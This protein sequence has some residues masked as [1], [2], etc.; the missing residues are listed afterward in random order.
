VV[1]AVEKA[2][3]LQPKIVIPIH[4]WHWREK[5]RERMYQMAADY[6]KSKGIEF[7]IPEN[8]ISV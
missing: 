2:V 7:M 5:A 3:K 4:D 1:A 6:L 8:K